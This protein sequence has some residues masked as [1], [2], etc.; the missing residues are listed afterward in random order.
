MLGLLLA[1]SL[2]ANAVV[3][4]SSLLPLTTEQADTLGSGL[5]E[6]SF[7]LR[8]ADNERFPFFTEPGALRSQTKLELP[9]MGFRIGAGDFVEIQ[10]DYEL[11]Y[12]DETAANGKTNW[13]Y[14]S[15]DAQLHTKVRVKREDDLWPALAVRF[16]TKLPD[17]NRS[18]RLGTDD[19][20][21]DISALGSKDLGP[22]SVHMN[23]G[24]LLLGNSGPFFNP[25]S[26]K[27]GGQDDIFTY[28]V[29]AV[30]A[31]FGEPSPEA[32]HLLLMAE[33]TGQGGT[34]YFND[35]HS[36]RLGAQISRGAGAIYLGTSF[37]LVTASENVGVIAGFIYNFDPSKWF[38]E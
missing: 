36:I 17:A 1:G 19:A 28:R 22:L 38:E 33:A 30:S 13:Q 23:L 10:A 2:P 24:L 31:P 12:L 7:G 29:A 16:G 18:D 26:F 27:A 25:N 32:A 34:H 37:G 5:S 6:V 21:F 14:G 20:D 9:T 35:R 11:I 8:Y 4:R 3:E 15:G